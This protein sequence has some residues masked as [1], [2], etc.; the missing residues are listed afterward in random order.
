[1]SHMPLCEAPSVA[2]DA[3]PVEHDGHRQPVQRDVHQQL[4]ERPVEERRVDRDDRVH[5][6]HRQAGG[7]GQRVL[8]GDADVEGP[9][10]ERARRTAA[11]P[12]GCSI[13]A[14]IATTSGRSAPIRTSSSENAVGPGRAGRGGRRA[15]V[16]V[17]DAG[18][19]PGV[20]LVGLGRRVAVALAW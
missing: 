10:G 6:A 7:R 15:A 17:E 5:A 4:V 2:G 12:V 19:V 11:S 1:M 13:A 14:V 8:L 20:D 9:L 18:G 3:G 16:G